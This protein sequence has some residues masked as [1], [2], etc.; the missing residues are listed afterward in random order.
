MLC[1]QSV[2]GKTKIQNVFIL[3]FFFHVQVFVV[4]VTMCREAFD[5]FT[6]FLRDKEVNSQVYKKVTK[7]GN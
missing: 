3:C 2:L 4:A 5:D 6:R 7:K 1:F